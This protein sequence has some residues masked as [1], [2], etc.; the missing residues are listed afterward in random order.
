MVNKAVCTTQIIFSCLFGFLY[1]CFPRNPLLFLTVFP[2]FPKILGVRKRRK[3]LAFFVVFLVFSKKAR[4]RK[5]GQCIII[6]TLRSRNARKMGPGPTPENGKI[7]PKKGKGLF[8]GVI[9][10]HFS[11]IS[12]VGLGRRICNVS[13][14]SGI[15][16]PKASRA[17]LWD[18]QLA[19]R[20]LDRQILNFS[21]P[22]RVPKSIRLVVK[23]NR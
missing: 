18:K 7:T 21:L 4:K 19:T 5:S 17:L 2:S 3:I 14:F 9:F 6:L 20:K 16:A 15:S 23:V 10:W 11:P 22:D 12:G 13:L 8:W 1:F